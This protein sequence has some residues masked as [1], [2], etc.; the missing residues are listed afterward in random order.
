MKFGSFAHTEPYGEPIGSA[1]V[2]PGDAESERVAEVP[3]QP[4]SASSASSKQNVRRFMSWSPVQARRYAARMDRGS[5]RTHSTQTGRAVYSGATTLVLVLGLFAGGHFFCGVIRSR[6]T[7]AR[8]LLSVRLVRGLLSVRVFAHDAEPGERRIVELAARWNVPGDLELPERGLSL[9]AE[10]A[11][12]RACVEA[13][14]AQLLLHL[15]YEARVGIGGRLTLGIGIRFLRM[16]RREFSDCRDAERCRQ[17]NRDRK[18]AHAHMEPAASYMPVTAATCVRRTWRSGRKFPF[19]ASHSSGATDR[20]HSSARTSCSGARRSPPGIRRR[21]TPAPARR[22]VGA[23]SRRG[24]A[25]HRRGGH[26]SSL[27][28]RHTQ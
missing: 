15:A 19:R 5:R 1:R 21:R 11:V 26:A 17:Q 27:Q 6:R 7:G 16:K 13:E 24:A 20:M 10:V 9:G 2:A 8:G 14:L 28:A 4:E 18:A 25:G 3:P 23:A 22:R 12:D